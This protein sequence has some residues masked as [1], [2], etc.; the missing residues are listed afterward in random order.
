MCRRFTTI[1]ALIWRKWN[2]KEFSLEFLPEYII[3]KMKIT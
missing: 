3:I 1:A 2:R